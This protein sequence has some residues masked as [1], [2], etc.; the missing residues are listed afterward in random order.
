[1]IQVSGG[2]WAAGPDPPPTNCANWQT[3]M[4]APT[5]GVSVSLHVKWGGLGD[6]GGPLQLCI[7]P[8]SAPLHAD[9]REP[10][11]L[12]ALAAAGS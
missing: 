8:V 9:D 11:V 1:M 2:R 7:Y 6:L 3:G 12:R 5:S 4:V 10:G